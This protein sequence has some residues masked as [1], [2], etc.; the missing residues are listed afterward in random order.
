MRKN[1]SVPAHKGA[2][3]QKNQARL[4]TGGYEQN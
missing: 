3:F 1:T 2:R 4:T